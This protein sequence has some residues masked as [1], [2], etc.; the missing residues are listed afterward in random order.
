MSCDFFLYLPAED[1]LAYRIGPAVPLT[2]GREEAA[3]QPSTRRP[4]T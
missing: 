1:S 4:T 2:I 3:A